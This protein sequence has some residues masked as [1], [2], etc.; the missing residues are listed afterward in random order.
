MAVFLLKNCDNKTDIASDPTPGDFFVSAIDG[1]KLALAS[2][3]Y[4]THAVALANVDRISKL[5]EK[6]DPKAVFYAWGTCKLPEN[7][8]K[9]GFVEK[10]GLS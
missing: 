7:S 3:P 2:G 4:P 9:V 6:A 10:Y 1:D 8:G 5:V